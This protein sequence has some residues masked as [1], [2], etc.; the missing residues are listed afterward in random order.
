MYASDGPTNPFTSLL[1]FA[2]LAGT[3]H[4]RWKGALSTALVC[5]LILIVVVASDA[6]ESLDLDTES[7]EDA[8]LTLFMIVSAT[9]LIWLGVREDAL[10]TDLLRLVV[11]VPDV[12]EDLGWPIESALGYV[13]R[14]IPAAR[15]VLIWADG[16][17]PWTYVGIREAGAITR[18]LLP[19][20][21][22]E[23]WVAN[24]ISSSSILNTSNFDGAVRVHRGGGRFDEWLENSPAVNPALSAAY[25]LNTYISVAFKVEEISARLFLVDPPR[26]SLDQVATAEIV[27]DRLR[28]LF[29]HS[30]LTRRLSHTAAVEERVKIGRELHDGF[31]QALAGTALTLENLQPLLGKSPEA[32]ARLKEIQASLA[33]EQSRFR[34]FVSTLE[35]VGEPREPGIS[36]PPLHFDL[37]VAQLRNQW[38]VDIRFTFEPQDAQL[39]SVTT[40]HVSKMLTDVVSTFVH[41]TDARSIAGSAKVIADSVVIDLEHDGTKGRPNQEEAKGSVDGDAILRDQVSRFGGTLRIETDHAGTRLQ[42]R[43]PITSE[44]G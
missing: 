9:L 29:E 7:T 32:V 27:A 17:E 34:T 16:E 20:D 8:S 22:Y 3:L 26:L 33:D 19:P 23:P 14:I 41:R 6:R 40:F 25:E 31:L 12:P 18:S 42:I 5:G 35:K 36:H 44:V 43:L 30:I 28:G 38:P 2:V 21:A 15:L 24:S 4:W 10:R 1:P 39:P 11:K 13:W 37:L